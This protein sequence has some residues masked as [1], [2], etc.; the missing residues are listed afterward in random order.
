MPGGGANAVGA[1]GHVGAMLELNEQILAGEAPEP[2]S[3]S[4]TRGS[5]YHGIMGF[6]V[7][8]WARR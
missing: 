3:E 5:L 4:T 8:T 2:E 6:I 7:F 1:L